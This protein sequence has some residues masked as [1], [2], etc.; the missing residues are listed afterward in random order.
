MFFQEALKLK[1]L[2]KTLPHVSECCFVIDC[3]L[4][5]K[6]Y[7]VAVYKYLNEYYL[8]QDRKVILAMNSIEDKV[9]N[10]ET[11][12]CLIE[13][14]LNHN[15]YLIVDENVVLMDLKILN[16]LDLAEEIETH[17]FEFGE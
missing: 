4:P 1:E 12:L 15:K 7:L 9:G 10:E 14:A 16:K 8:L 2:V 13:E 17:F 11:V 5:N 6:K 3:V